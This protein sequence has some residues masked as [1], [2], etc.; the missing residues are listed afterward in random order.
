MDLGTVEPLTNPPGGR[1]KL[2]R[3]STGS[4]RG[5]GGGDDGN[6]G[7]GFGGPNRS[8]SE[9]SPYERPDKS[10]VVTWFLLLV[11]L[12]TFGGLMG[13]YV[14]VATNGEAEWQPF[15]L[16]VQLWVSTFILAC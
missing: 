13:A 9:G 6:G 16:P 15:D 10:R 11:V 7:G 4:T 12:M 5:S 2:R 3:V 8:Q 14:V 1:K